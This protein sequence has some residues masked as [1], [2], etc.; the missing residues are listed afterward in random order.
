MIYLTSPCFPAT[1]CRGD[2]YTVRVDL[3]SLA[4]T[5]RQVAVIVFA[6]NL[7]AFAISGTCRTKFLFRIE[8]EIVNRSTNK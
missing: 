1:F 7:R 5:R 3:P 4:D 6:T 8:K 2:H